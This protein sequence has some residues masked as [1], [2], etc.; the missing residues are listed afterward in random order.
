[1]SKSVCPDWLTCDSKGCPHRKPHYCV[2]PAKIHL[3]LC[4]DLCERYRVCTRRK[5]KG[6]ICGKKDGMSRLDAVQQESQRVR[7]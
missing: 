5:M 2:E 7:A 3:P 4:K 6:C 1:M